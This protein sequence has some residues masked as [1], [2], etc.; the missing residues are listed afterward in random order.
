MDA[1]VQWYYLQGAGSQGPVTLQRL[2]ELL[3]SGG[4]AR[5]TPVMRA[6]GADWQSLEQA[7]EIAGH[8]PPP[9]AGSAAA[10]PPE[11]P[12]LN[13]ATARSPAGPD[14]EQHPWLRYFARMIDI[15]VSGMAMLFLIDVV[16]AVVN[17]DMSKAFTEFLGQSGAGLIVPVL[18][19][20]PNAL[21]IGFTGATIGKWLFGIRVTRVDGQPIG[22]GNALRREALVWFRGLGIG[23]PLVSLFTLIRAYSRLKDEGRTT[24]DRDMSLSVQ[25]RSHT[26]FTILGG[27]LLFAIICAVVILTHG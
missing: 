6:D 25:Y 3:D 23:F 16:L 18:A 12:A 7:L 15:V 24:W 20:F 21:M 8:A 26:I 14:G 4:I 2:L 5:T 11:R 13:A 19:M 27:V 1:E 17:Q 22:V 9:L 10:V